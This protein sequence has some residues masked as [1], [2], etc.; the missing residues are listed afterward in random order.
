MADL[1]SKLIQMPMIKIKYPI[2]KCKFYLKNI[3]MR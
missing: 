3:A 2:V 1:A